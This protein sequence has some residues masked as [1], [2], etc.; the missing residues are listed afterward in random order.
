MLKYL[1][2]AAAAAITVAAYDAVR[3]VWD[4]C[5]HPESGR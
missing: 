3:D 2:A 4:C 1:A 5:P